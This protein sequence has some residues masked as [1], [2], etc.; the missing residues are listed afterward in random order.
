MPDLEGQKYPISA[1]IFKDIYFFIYLLFIYLFIY[2]L[3]N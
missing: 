3:I 2:L 1:F